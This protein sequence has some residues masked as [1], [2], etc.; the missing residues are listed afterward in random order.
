MFIALVNPILLVNTKEIRKVSLT[1]KG[2][3]EKHNA[4]LRALSIPLILLLDLLP[5]K[6]GRALYLAF[7][8]KDNNRKELIEGVKTS[9]ALEV[10][11]TYHERRN[12]GELNPVSIF[13]GKFISNS[14][15]LRN[16]LHLVRK[17]IAERAAEIAERKGEVN[18]LS[19]G[20]GSARPVIEAVAMLGASPAVKI[21]MVD[22]DREAIQFSKRLATTYDVNHSNWVF[23]NFFRLERICKDFHPDLIEVVGLLDY[24]DRQRAVDLLTKTFSILNPDGY[25]ITGNVSPNIEVPFVTKTMM[26]PMIYR[27]PKDLFDLLTQ[28]GFKAENIKIMKEPLGIHMVAIA[29]K[30]V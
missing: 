24:L 20:S 6:I 4:V 28:S 12:Q 2:G 29:R 9:R 26:W 30:L 17:T 13:W 1:G 25:L 3:Y 5:G 15:A 18:I 10:M 19:V 16:R 23:G 14:M 22:M 21:M 8:G 11:Y 7:S 27:R